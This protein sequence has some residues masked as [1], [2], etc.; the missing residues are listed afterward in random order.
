[1]C[2]H[3]LVSCSGAYNLVRKIKSVYLNTEQYVIAKK[4]WMQNDPLPKNMER[5]INA[6]CN[7]EEGLFIA[8]QHHMETLLKDLKMRQE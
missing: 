6:K 5:V 7:Q 8:G 2:H 3:R 4:S 1:M